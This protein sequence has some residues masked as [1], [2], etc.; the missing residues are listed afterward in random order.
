MPIILPPSYDEISEFT[1]RQYDYILH[2]RITLFLNVKS[3][4]CSKCGL[5]NFGRNLRCADK[6]CQTERPNGYT[7]R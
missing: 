1:K 4:I 2:R 3:W 5:T 7:K 6:L